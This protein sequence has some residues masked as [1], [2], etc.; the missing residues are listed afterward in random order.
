[1]SI[2]LNPAERRVARWAA[3]V[4]VTV[5]AVWII[6]LELVE[7]LLVPA[8]DSFPTRFG[9]LT[10][11]REAVDYWVHGGSLYDYASQHT[12]TL[13]LGFTYPPFAAIILAPAMLVS[14][15]WLEVA[16]TL[17]TY[18]VATLLL[19]ITV[20]PARLRAGRSGAA[21]DHI[22]RTVRIVATAWVMLGLSYP[23]IANVIWGQV[24]L[25][26]I[27]LCLVDAGGAVPGRFKGI[28]IGLVAAVKLTPLI[29]IPYFLITGQRRSA[30]RATSTFL[31]ATGLAFAVDPTDSIDY[32]TRDVMNTSRVGDLGRASNKSLLA[33]LMRWHAGGDLQV[34]LWLSLCLLIGSYALVH[35]WQS[36]AWG[37]DLAAALTVGCLSVVVSPVSWTHHQTWGVVAALALI[38]GGRAPA[39]RAGAVLYAVFLLEPL[40]PPDTTWLHGPGSLL[41]RACTEVPVVAFIVVSILGLPSG[42]L[43]EVDAAE[44]LNIDEERITDPV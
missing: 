32:W 17:G 30:A 36:F 31:L 26:V 39:M 18:V 5:L 40:I 25:V 10:I 27:A 22:A 29:F 7:M 4:I 43:T 8:R 6:C 3:P 14:P 11:Y 41:L 35:A 21:P 19:W 28:L 15:R 24:S 38:A 42:R 2:Q 1:M 13:G 23:F 34:E 37:D 12:K 20:T 9:D 16:W 44:L 33:L